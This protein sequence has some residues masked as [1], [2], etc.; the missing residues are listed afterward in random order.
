M[1]EEVIQT[2][3]V[4]SAGESGQCMTGVSAWTR[5]YFDGQFDPFDNSCGHWNDSNSHVA[6]PKSLWIQNPPDH[7]RHTVSLNG[8]G[9]PMCPVNGMSPVAPHFSLYI[10]DASRIVATA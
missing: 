9:H 2:G 10:S 4:V 1:N 8:D 7:G 5:T 3:T 6:H